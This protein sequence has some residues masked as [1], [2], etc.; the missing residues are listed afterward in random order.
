MI[1]R[2]DWYMIQEMREKGCYIRDIAAKVQ[3]SAKTVSRALKRGGPSPRRKAGIRPSK[4]D[5]FKD[6]IDRLLNED[7]WNA[8]VIYSVIKEQGYKGGKTILRGYIQPKRRL[9]QLKGTVRF[10]TPPGKQLQHDWGE[11]TRVVGGELR[12]I[13]FAVNTLG[14]SRRF[15]VWGAFKNDAEHTYESL[16]RSFE[17]FGGVAEEVWVDNQKAAVNSHHPERGAIFNQGFRLLADHYGFRPRACKP[18][19][20]QTKG[21]DE[22]MVGYV[23]NNFFQRYR[24]FEDLSHLNQLF[25]KWLIEVADLRVHGTVKE[26]VKERFLKEQETLQPLSPIRFDTS[27]RQSRRVALDGYI[28]VRGNR[29]SV[30]CHLCGLMV[31]IRICLDGVLKV[32]DLEDQLVAHHRLREKG[33]S[34]VPEHHA[35]LWQE[36]MPVTRDL[37]VYEEVGSW[38]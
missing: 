10:E 36:V 4:L 21:K 8:E 18:G 3:C 34:T 23:K 16:L 32:Y 22:R 2:E 35:R 5:N 24:E 17:W 11:I 37:K 12:K 15:H 20:P 38:S 25:E 30:P 31:S 1:N 6:E 27:Y 28:D 26:V 9:R 13:Y 7:V 19:R 29:Y 33:W 14:Y